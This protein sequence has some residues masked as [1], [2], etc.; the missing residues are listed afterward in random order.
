[1]SAHES[2]SIDPKRVRRG[3]VPRVFD[4]ARILVVDDDP[5]SRSAVAAV[6][7]R[8]GAQV[9]TARG[10][11]E[12]LGL[13]RAWQPSL[14][15]SDLAMA[16]GD[17]YFLIACVRALSIGRAVPAVVLSGATTLAERKRTCAAGFDAHLAKPID[18]GE[19][20]TVLSR[21]WRGSRPH[22]A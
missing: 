5:E 12:A 8:A 9:Q 2:E 11:M 20:I 10:G 13:V 3:A 17:G 7:T 14:I 21:L 22:E 16:A 1:M 4:G 15:V 6:L 18:A 19:L